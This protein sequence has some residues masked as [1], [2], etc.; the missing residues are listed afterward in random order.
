ML[1]GSTSRYIAGRSVVQT[2]Y[3]RTTSNEQGAK[4]FKHGRVFTLAESP[5]DKPPPAIYRK[6]YVCSGTMKTGHDFAE[7]CPQFASGK[8]SRGSLLQ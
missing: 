5:A 3:W 6:D 7:K 8:H 1:I 2:V 4:M